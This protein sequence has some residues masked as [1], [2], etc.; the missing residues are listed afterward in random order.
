MSHHHTMPDD[1]RTG[2]AIIDEEIASKHYHMLEGVKSS[3][4]DNSETHTHMINGQLTSRPTESDNS[5][6]GNDMVT[7]IEAEIETKRIGG[8]VTEVKEA[9]RNGVKV[10]IIEGYIAT[11][12]VDRGDFF[13]VKDQF[14][15]GCF[16]E[17]IAD[18]LKRGR[19]VRL[20]D[21]HERTVGGFPIDTV[22]EDDRGLFGVGEI[23]L[24]VQQGF[25][26]HSL[27]L[28]G[29]I[30]DFSIGFSVEEFT[31]DGDLRII[32]KA[33]IWEGSIVDEPMNPAAVVTA[34]KSVVP[35]QDLQLADKDREWDAKEAI[36]RV[37]EFTKSEEAPTVSYKSSFVQYDKDNDTTFA[38]YKLPIADVVDGKLRAVP[39]GI[40][41]AAND[42]KNG[43]S[44]IPET[45]LPGVIRHIERYYA[46]MDLPSPFEGDDK[47]YFIA[48]DIEKMDV[49]ALEKAL[50]RS[51][52]F[53][54][55]ASKMLAGKLAPPTKVDD[56]EKLNNTN[57]LRGLLSDIER[58]KK[59]VSTG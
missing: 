20:K 36:Q 44:G 8:V 47:Q 52:S 2:N 23:N 6:K 34:V 19:Q 31:M 38:A 10:G 54:K 56:D 17:S 42:I 59:L 50:K 13:G 51:G 46:K 12:D 55:S 58:T 7:E 30:V 21:N 28:Q 39:K 33:V 45:D 27:A 35:Y 18:H 26:L 9:V 16:R 3:V 57:A 48:D 4:E 25:E 49:R 24:D 5:N 29:V 15:K 37:K 1:S 53:S 41:E 32:T 43:A 11:W 40:F 14:V 22:R